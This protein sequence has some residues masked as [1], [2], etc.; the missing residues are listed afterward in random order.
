PLLILQSSILLSGMFVV[1]RLNPAPPKIVEES[2]NR[3]RQ[4]TRGLAVV[5]QSDTMRPAI[6]MLFCMS[7]FYGGTFMVLNPLIVRDI[8][9]G[10]AA[11]ISLSYSVFVV[12]TVTS[13]VLMVTFGGIRR[14]GRAMILAVVTAGLSLGISLFEPPFYGY[15][16]SICGWGLCGGVSI[17]MSRTIMQLE[18]P[19]EMRARVMSVFTLGN[20][21]GMPLGALTLGYLAQYF[22]VL[23]ALT[24][25]ILGIWTMSLLIWRFTILKKVGD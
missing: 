8:Y 20:T 16:A 24:F 18:A 13:T 15:L 25:V 12:G 23:N 3:F 4:I 6:L 9:G 10:S 21:G 19:E 1:S 2:R 5:W 7:F 11:E 22:G 17:S 14:H